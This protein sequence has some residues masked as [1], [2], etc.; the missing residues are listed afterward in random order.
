MAWKREEAVAVEGVWDM[1]R[2]ATAEE[3]IKL[4]GG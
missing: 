3:P 4:C 1:T 2:V